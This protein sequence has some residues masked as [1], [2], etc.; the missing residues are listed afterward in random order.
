MPTS[1]MCATCVDGCIG[2][3]EIGKSAYRGHEVIYPQPFGVITC[4]GEKKYPVDYSHFNIMGTAAG[5]YGIEAD[6]DKAI[7]PAVN[8]EVAIGYDKGVKFK[9]PWLISGIGSTNIAK[10]NWEGLAIG[11]ALAGTGLTIGEN[12]VGMDPETK[13]KNGKIV[14]TVDLK[15]RVK[16][17]TDN[18]RDGYGA[19]IVQANVEDSRLKVQEYAIEKLGVECVEL[20][21]GQGAKD[22]GGE[23]KIK[24]LKKAQMLQERG[25]IVLPNP[26]DPNV[27]EAFKRGAFKEFERHSRVGMVTE[28]SF[29]ATIEGLRKAGA[30]YIFLKTGAYRP[31]DL[32]RAIAFSSKYRLDL[33][34]V[35][36]AG[37]GTGMSPWR[38]MNEWGVPPVEL[39]TLVYQ[40]AKELADKK[41]H[42]PAIAVNGGFSFEDQ[43]FK[44]LAMGAPYVKMVGMARAPIA[45][46]MVGKTIGKTI[47]AQQVPVYIERFGT[48][49]D[50]IFVTASSLR[51]ELGNKEFEKLPTGAIGLYTYYERLAQGLRQLMAGSRKFALEHMSRNDLAALTREA[52]DVSNI[53]FIM[54]VDKK[55]ALN[56]LDY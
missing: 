53:Q 39:H 7:F 34:T 31:V 49:K 16:L 28:E 44:G 6:S 42:L 21:W 14:D 22:I 13:F 30:K 45:A 52:A 9:L 20:K 33:L 4:A 37:G 12:V 48:S 10:N 18:Q 46:A 26:N 41:K 23:V 25:Y 56:I 36:A 55:E 24:D 43:I 8:L 38:M 32:A 5:A 51:K 11:S 27:I 3:C 47:E 2:M 40:Y 1:G 50:E 15:R 54:D 19:I 35:D 17:Y 29:A